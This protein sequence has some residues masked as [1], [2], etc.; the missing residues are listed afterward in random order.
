[1]CSGDYYEAVPRLGAHR[2]GGPKT[3][4][5]WPKI[6]ELQASCLSVVNEIDRLLGLEQ[7]QKGMDA[8]G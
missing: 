5:L 4:A 2:D 1:M 7:G 3:V 8:L 6:R